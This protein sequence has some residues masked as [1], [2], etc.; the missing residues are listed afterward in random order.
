VSL[1]IEPEGG[2][3]RKY[4]NQLPVGGPAGLLTPA[5]FFVVAMFAGVLTLPPHPCEGCMQLQTES[6]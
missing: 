1:G 6:T 4:R 2:S 5:A 3:S